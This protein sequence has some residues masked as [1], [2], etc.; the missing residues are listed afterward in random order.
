MN[1]ATPGAGPA[2]RTGTLLA[3]ALAA[4][5]AVATVAD[6]SAA[7]GREGAGRA[8]R[9]AKPGPDGIVR[10]PLE[11]PA[12]R[13]GARLLRYRHGPIEVKPGQNNIDFTAGRVAKPPV[14]GWVVGITPDL[15]FRSGRVP[16]VDVVH[17]HHGVWLN[18]SRRDAT[19]RS[20]PERFFAA[21]EEKTIMRLPQG[22]GYRYRASDRWVINYMLHNLTS[23]T[24]RLYLTYDIEFIPDG[25][26]AARGITEA[27][28]L[29]MDV[30]NGKIYPVFDVLRGQGR[31]GRV[32]YP[33]D[34]R[35]PY[36]DR[37]PANTWTVDRDG[38]LLATAGH[39]HPGG[40]HT[41]LWLRRPGATPT[42]AAAGAATDDGRVRL[43]RSQARYY[44]PAGPVSWDLSMTA[45]PADWRVGV[46]AGDELST[47]VTYETRRASWYES[48]GIM[49]LWMADG[50]GPDPYRRRVDAP[51]KV[52][53]G[54]LPE[55][56]N[57]G[58]ERTRMPDPRRLPDGPAVRQVDS[59]EFAYVPGGFDLGEPLAP[60]VVRQGESLRFV[61][62]DA[63]L[64]NGIWHTITS[65]RAPC[66][67]STGIAYPLADGPV[68]F[69]S[70]ELGVA[71]PPTANRLT[72]ETPKDLPP[73]TYT[74]FC[75]IHPSMR[76]AFRVVPR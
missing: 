70:G 67:R 30:E 4:V 8:A 24:Y 75:R 56:R 2:R 11:P 12:P 5:V 68:V 27:R 34:Y 41:E 37:P 53:H 38:V 57:H 69:D 7:E 51:G 76:G 65:C 64:D 74:F 33:D 54:P 72:W 43:F 23:N 50:T 28:P 21:G 1:P 15:K 44:E 32:T 20:L 18:M 16:R 26:P 10:R 22:Y 59:V 13:P 49:V 55:N 61:N 62:R 47:S 19:V 36:G 17:L 42:K 48:M 3:V 52:T 60:P 25:S 63:P 46:R 73:G 6:P 71:G 31:D 66:N 14:D 45:T 9:A 58:G 29:W 35:D 39:L 40:L